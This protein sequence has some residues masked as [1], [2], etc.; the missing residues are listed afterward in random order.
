MAL[1]THESRARKHII[2]ELRFFRKKSTRQS[3]GHD[4]ETV[5]NERQLRIFYPC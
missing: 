5:V 4:S 3:Q 1:D 2:K